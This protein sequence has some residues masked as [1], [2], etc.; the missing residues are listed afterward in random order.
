MYPH[1]N[2]HWCH[3]KINNFK[4]NDIYLSILITLCYILSLNIY[5]SVSIYLSPLLHPLER[6]IQGTTPLVLE[7]KK[8]NILKIFQKSSTV[9]ILHYCLKRGVNSLLLIPPSRCL[10]LY[11]EY[12][13]VDMISLCICMCVPSHPLKEGG[14]VADEMH[15]AV[16]HRSSGYIY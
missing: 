13:C 11:M 2:H 7:I 3:D 1:C 6:S 15:F 9:L 10:K 12:R 8:I 4:K 16:F 5:L 14:G